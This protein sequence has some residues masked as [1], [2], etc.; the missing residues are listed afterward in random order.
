MTMK[1]N[2]KYLTQRGGSWQ[3]RRRVPDEIRHV[4]GKREWVVSLGRVSQAQAIRLAEHHAADTDRE[5]LSARVDAKKTLTEHDYSAIHDKAFALSLE[6][7]GSIEALHANYGENLERVI[8]DGLTPKQKALLSDKTTFSEAFE[9]DQKLYKV[10]FQKHQTIGLRNF[11]RV[12]G[13]VAVEDVTRDQVMSYVHDARRRGLAES[14][15]KR[16]IGALGAVVNRYYQDHD[17]SRRNPFARVPLIGA[18]A[19]ISDREPISDEQVAK[20]DAYLKSNNAI[21]PHIKAVFWLVRCSSL[22]P[23]EA[24]GLE[25]GDVVVAHEVPHVVV[26]SNDLRGI[27][28]RS[29]FRMYP[30]VGEALQWSEHLPTKRFNANGVSQILNKHLKKAISD[31]GD[32]QSVYSLRHRMKDK[33]YQAGASRDQAMYL[34]GHARNTAHDRYGSSIPA[35]QELRD[36]A[37]GAV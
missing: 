22:G 23:S 26:R 6:R 34:M 12:N 14:S 13:D 31:L 7:A 18:A 37:R 5:I 2:V 29:R 8:Q 20:L 15:I 28:A 35:L 33:L 36:L 32:R 27:K 9:R 1:L 25:L 10:T 21:D 24:G 16:R 4:V 3:F 30:L 11:I 19:K 17:I